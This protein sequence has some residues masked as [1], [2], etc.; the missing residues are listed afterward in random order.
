[1]S[2]QP[3]SLRSLLDGE[4]R[5]EMNL[6]NQNNLRMRTENTHEINSSV[7]AK[8][9]DTDKDL[10]LCMSS[11]GPNLAERVHGG[12]VTARRRGTSPSMF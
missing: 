5:K 7:V 12:S 1:M 2:T 9:R 10:T 6:V 8:N 11:S 4:K 3:A